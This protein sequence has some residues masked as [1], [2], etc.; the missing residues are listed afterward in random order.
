MGNVLEPREITNDD[1]SETLGFVCKAIVLNG[2]KRAA[3][4]SGTVN[5]GEISDG[6]GIFYL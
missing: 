5:L 2:V 1:G 6:S 4:T 3:S